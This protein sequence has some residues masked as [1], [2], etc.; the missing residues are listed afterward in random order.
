MATLNGAISASAS[1]LS[2]ERARIEVAVSNMANAESTRSANGEPY[3]RRD[4]VLVSDPVNSFDGALGKA[5]AT[6]VKVADIVVDQSD[7]QR[8]YEPSHP[9]ADADGFV[10]LPNVDQ[11]EEMVDML[12]AARAYQ[13]NLAAISM[14][15]DLVAKALELGRS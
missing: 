5:S 6:G 13:A 4:V 3:R 2:A 7:F 1:A 15:R 12:S 11:S 10:A 14:I 9:D 8:R